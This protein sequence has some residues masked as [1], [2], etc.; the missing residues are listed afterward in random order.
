[1]PVYTLPTFNLVCS[2]WRTGWA[3]RTYAAPDVSSPCNLTP[4]RRVFTSRQAAFLNTAAPASL[5]F[6]LLPKLTDIRPAIASN[7]TE[8]LVEVP[9][10]SK[11]FYEVQQVDDIGKGFLN[12]HRFATLL[13]TGGT[14]SFTDTGPIPVPVPIP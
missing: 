6:L 11:R 13:W 2:I 10:G 3:A 5:M 8:D 12:E 14:Q 4:G 7:N 1:M 9:A